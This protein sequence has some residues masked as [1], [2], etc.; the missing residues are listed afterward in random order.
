MD[1]SATLQIVH[2]R[3]WDFPEV[4]PGIVRE[5][6][7]PTTLLRNA[8]AYAL[9]AGGRLAAFCALKPHGPII[10]LGNVYTPPALRGKGHAT[11]LLRHV[12]RKYPRLHLFC[13]PHLVP[14][15]ERL[16]FRVLP[17]VPREFGTRRAYIHGLNALGHRL[18]TM[19]RDPATA[20]ARPGRHAGPRPS[21]RP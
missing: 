18:V 12:I 14:F 4:V 2:G 1:R 9:Y 15:Y 20:G 11:R 6:L 13:R 5:L 10:E 16:G 8:E 3:V 7:D 19:R 17:D 21:G